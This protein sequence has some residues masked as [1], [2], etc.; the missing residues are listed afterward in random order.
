[1][2]HWVAPVKFEPIHC[3]AKE[4]KRDGIVLVVSNISSWNRSEMH[5][6]ASTIS[7]KSSRLYT[8]QADHHEEMRLLL[9]KSSLGE[10][11]LF[12]LALELIFCHVSFPDFV[13]KLSDLRLEKD[14]W[15]QEV[16]F[17]RLV[18]FVCAYHRYPQGQE[19]L[20]GAWTL[21]LR[22]YVQSHNSGPSQFRIWVCLCSQ[23]AIPFLQWT[24]N[25]PR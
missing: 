16:S 6:Y 10:S 12:P 4:D 11:C 20:L 9:W 19:E 15:L 3:W 14:S 5:H 7:P 18:A 24:N 1:M 8:E 2:H 25:H 23:G 17:D 13:S 22:K 21:L